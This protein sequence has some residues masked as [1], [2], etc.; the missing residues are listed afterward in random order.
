MTVITEHPDRDA[1]A[2]PDTPYTLAAGER[3]RGT[4]AEPTDEDRV[5][6]ELVAG[7]TYT[8]T[9][10][11]IGPDPVTDTVLTV[12]DANGN[13]VAR[14]DDVSTP[15]GQLHSRVTFT[16]ET[17]GTYY[18]NAAAYTSNPDLVYAGRYELRLYDAAGAGAGTPRAIPS[19][20]PT[21]SPPLRPPAI[22]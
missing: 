5:R 16:P 6:I 15:G 2:T 19:P 1:P 17:S 3:F 4:L 9:L 10:G 12:Y 8:V 13:E 22:P 20:A 11:G 14:N 7:E 21:P 18:L